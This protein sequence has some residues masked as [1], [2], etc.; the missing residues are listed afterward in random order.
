M[1][2]LGSTRT[3]NILDRCLFVVRNTANGVPVTVRIQYKCLVPIYVFPEIKLRGLT[4][5][6]FPKQNDNVLS[7]NFHIHVPVSD[8]YVAWTVCLFFCSQRCRLI[9]GI[10]TSLTDT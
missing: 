10:Y 7:P 8:L 3:R 1:H 5:S 9:L 6:L 4:A 2:T